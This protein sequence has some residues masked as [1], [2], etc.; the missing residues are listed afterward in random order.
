MRTMLLAALG[1]AALALGTGHA[2]QAEAGLKLYTMDC[3]RIAL[4]DMSLFGDGSGP[5][6][7]KGNL[8]SPCY[9]IRHAKGDLLWDTGFGDAIHAMPDHVLEPGPGSRIT[10]PVTLAAQ[11]E[12]LGL[13]PADIKLVAFSHFHFDHTGNAGLFPDATW[14]VDP[15]EVAYAKREPT[16]FGVNPAATAGHDP[17]RTIEISGDHDVFGDG[18]VTMLASPGHT[19]GHYM[20][21]LKL[22]SGPLLLSGDLWH[23][24]ENFEKGIV[25]GFNDDKAATLASFE[26]IKGVLDET[27]ARLVIQHEIPDFD[28]LPKFP[29]ALE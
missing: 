13:K 27:K 19:P 9:L 10:V 18:T 21:L 28:A 14:I 15:K 11:L 3:G 25:P 24:H 7:V 26:H 23:T 5:K 17:A 4:D 16:P 22:D 6:G 1:A 8:I 29:A 20:L 2:A 12:Q